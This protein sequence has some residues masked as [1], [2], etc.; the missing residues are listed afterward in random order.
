MNRGGICRM[1]Y[2]RRRLLLLLYLGTDRWRQGCYRGP[3][4]KP[5]LLPWHMAVSAMGIIWWYIHLICIQRFKLAS[6]AK[7]TLIAVNQAPR[8]WLITRAAAF[9]SLI[10]N[11]VVNE[12]C[13]RNDGLLFRVIY[14]WMSWVFDGNQRRKSPSVAAPASRVDSSIVEID[15][16][17]TSYRYFSKRTLLNELES[18]SGTR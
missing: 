16:I 9:I 3:E 5:L 4:K 6:V 12:L 8:F 7:A 14:Y 18:T 15:L 17:S 1:N 2:T 11:H 13:W 10:F